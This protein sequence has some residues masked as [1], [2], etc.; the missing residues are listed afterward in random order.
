MDRRWGRAATPT[1]TAL[2]SLARR[3]SFSV[4]FFRVDSCHQENFVTPDDRRGAALA[5]NFN[6]PLQVLAVA[7]PVDRWV[8]ICRHT[9][10][11]RA[12]KT[13]PV[14]RRIICDSSQRK[15]ANK[16]G[17]D[18]NLN[19][20]NGVFNKTEPPQAN[21]SESDYSQLSCE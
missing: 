16:N 10:P 18:A 17:D 4:P 3:D 1:T 13:V 6:F 12:S 5:G 15:S 11:I 20:C 7:T 19:G 9:V 8:G 21:K 2:L 14:L